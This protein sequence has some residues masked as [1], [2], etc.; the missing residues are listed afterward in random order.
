RQMCIRDRPI[1]EHIIEL[2]KSHSIT[3][4]ILIL[5]HQGDIIKDYFRDGR[6]FGVKITYVKPDADYGTAGA[7]HCAYDVI[8]GR[9]LVISG[10]VVTDF[11][12]EHALK[13]HEKRNSE[14]TIIL[15]RS[16][17]PLQ[18]G[19]VLTDKDGKITR[20]FE[21]P[22]WSEVFSDTINTGIYI[23]EK[24]TLALVPKAR[25]VK[26]ECDFSK[27]LFPYLLRHKMKLYG[28]V[29]KGYWRDVGSLEDY[30]NTN[31]DALKGKVSLPL[32]KG[33]VKNGSVIS[34]SSSVSRKAKIINSVI[35]SKCRISPDTV[36]KNS[37][38]WN[39]SFI[40]EN[41]KIDYSV[42][43]NNVRIRQN[44]VINQNVYIGDN[45]SIGANS[46]IKPD[47]KIWPGKS[48]DSGS[49]VTKNLIWEEKWRESLFTDSRIT[50]LANI[51]ITPDF[52][53]K[54]GM[55]YGVFAG[56]GSKIMVA[57][58]ID[59]VS[60]MIKG[61]IT[62]GLLSSGVDVMDYHTIPLPVLRGELKDKI[63]SAGGVF[64]RKS[65]FDSSK[66]DIIFLDSGGKDLSSAKTK[67]VERLVISGDYR[68]IPFDKIG[69]V[70]SETDALE[71]YKDRFIS[72]L[73]S[74]IINKRSFKIAINFSHGL[75]S[76]ILTDIIGNY[77]IELVTLDS[78]PDP[79]K[80]VRSSDEFTNA[81]KQLSYIVT[82]LKYDAGFLID[83]GGE[84]IYLVDDKGKILSYDRFLSVIVYLFLTLYPNTKKIAVPI[85][86]SGEID[87]VAKKYYTDVIRV[88][89]SHFA[90]MNA[91]D[92][93]DVELAGGTKGGVI[94]PNFLFAT[95]GMFT[96]MKILE[97][98]A[99][100][101]KTLSELE[102]STPRLYMSKNNVFCPKDLKGRIMRK[103]VEESAGFRRQ[104]IDGIKIFFEDYKWVLCIPDS[105]REI[106]HVN[107][108]ARTQKA[109]DELVRQ[110]SAKIKKLSQSL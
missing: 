42:I 6:K 20:F 80:Q 104:L 31:L 4:L 85:Q 59:N 105:E 96:I 98:L 57:R 71:K 26:T 89:D 44:T 50:G 75:S 86:A 94:F 25:G 97:L 9:F 79:T 77:N 65:P 10:D 19:I 23:L 14:A 12:F 63:Y 49:A 16:K 82:S 55:A 27:D 32:A 69:S 37:I 92:D 30:I 48:V 67:S 11:R 3:D 76:T 106:F 66:C 83:A 40:D 36:I 13:F 35:G 21:K 38:I 58:D 95:D 61:A 103:L 78:N 70:S 87:I 24:E 1:I 28:S 18:F 101:G 43:C 8:E 60:L 15:T 102:K 108:E 45:V 84:K 7:V 91:T 93:P 54:L 29:L 62:S 72:M 73:N 5:Y 39:N 74:E 90:I 100:S 107:A 64:V 99:I 51:E 81:L 109:A 52:G 34:P 46:V 88:K 68:P 47:I 41:V 33:K 22:S 2:L 110:Y 53:A 17:N 56:I